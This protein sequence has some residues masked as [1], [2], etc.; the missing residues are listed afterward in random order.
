[1]DE[2]QDSELIRTKVEEAL[3]FFVKKLPSD[4]PIRRSAN[5]AEGEAFLEI[6]GPRNESI[7]FF[8]REGR[9]EMQFG[10]GGESFDFA[11]IMGDDDEDAE[12]V[13]P[14]TAEAE[15]EEDFKDEL[16]ALVNATLD[17]I[18]EGVFS[19]QYSKLSVQMGGLFPADDFEDMKG[20][21]GFESV[22][23]NGKYDVDA[24]V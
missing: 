13:D 1:M 23:W 10:F 15:V 24:K 17:V 6:P 7:E 21:E 16:E 14:E 18:E 22:S 9:V 5:P 2:F 11:G 8:E 12:G 3:R 20:F 4:L 19:A